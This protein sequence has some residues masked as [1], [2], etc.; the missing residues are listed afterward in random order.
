MD[1]KRRRQADRL[2]NQVRW[3]AWASFTAAVA[4]LAVSIVVLITGSQDAIDSAGKWVL[5][6]VLVPLLA[7]DK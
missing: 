7:L 1:E 5:S 6:G 4:S 3:L 2:E